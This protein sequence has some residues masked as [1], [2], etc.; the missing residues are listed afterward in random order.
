[1]SREG[2]TQAI[3]TIRKYLARLGLLLTPFKS[4][5]MGYVHS[6]PDKFGNLVEPPATPKW[7]VSE[8]MRIS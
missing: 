5:V 4:N 8:A 1:M 2:I 3:A 7:D 6:L